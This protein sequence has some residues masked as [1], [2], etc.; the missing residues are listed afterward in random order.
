MYSEIIRKQTDCY[1]SLKSFSNDET[2]I[3]PILFYPQNKYYANKLSV[4]LNNLSE[5]D[6]NNITQKIIIDLAKE[7]INFILQSD[8]DI[9]HKNKKTGFWYQISFKMNI[10]SEL[11]VKILVIGSD[12]KNKISKIFFDNI[13]VLIES[14]YNIKHSCIYIQWSKNHS[15]PIKDNNMELIYGLDGIKENILG[16]DFI[17][18]PFTFSQANP[19]TCNLLY[20]TIHKFINIDNINNIIC[21]GRNVGHICFT[22]KKNISIFGY[23]PCNVVDKDLRR[24]LDNNNINSAIYLYLDEKCE[25]V[26]HK[27]GEQF[28]KN[29]VIILSPGR[30][31]LKNNV[32]KSIRKNKINIKKFYYVSCYSKSLVR[33]L[34]VIGNCLITRM[35]P[36]NLFPGTPFYEIILEIELS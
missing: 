35:Q 2:V 24:T 8:Y 6:T 18:T 33:D 13:L 20:E 4:D 31:G 22:I 25:L 1:Q 23:N 28:Y 3:Y 10:N 27:L 19:N 26:S 34:E 32:A 17:I 7:W 12:W 29:T 11:M 5:I 9:Y 15:C 36:I 16:I 14:K 30:N 21:Y